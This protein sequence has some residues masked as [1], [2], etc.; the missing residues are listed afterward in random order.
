MP[1]VYK[2]NRN[3]PPRVKFD[4]KTKSADGKV[5]YYSYSRERDLIGLPGYILIAQGYALRNVDSTEDFYSE[6]SYTIVKKGSHKKGKIVDTVLHTA[7]ITST[8]KS[9]GAT[10]DGTYKSCPDKA[11]VNFNNKTGLRTITFY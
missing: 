8:I 10:Y 11:T 4:N 1:C 9:D 5:E 2:Y 6:E 3:T 7:T